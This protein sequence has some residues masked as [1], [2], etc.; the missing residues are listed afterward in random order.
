MK[1]IFKILAIASLG[2]VS[3]TSCTRDLTSLNVDPKHATTLPSENQLATAMYYTAYNMASPSVNSNN[4]RFF[5]Q[6]LAETTYIDETNYDL[7]TRLQPRN[8]FNNMYSRG[9]NPIRLAKTAL[10]AEANSTAI[11]NNKWATLELQEIFVWENL[12][13]TYGNIPYTDA[14]N[15]DQTLAPKYDDAA[16][17]YTDL[18]KRIDAAVAKISTGAAGY[19]NGGDLV[20]YGDMAKWKKFG[21]SLKL[22][23]AMNLADVNPSV[24]KSAAEAAVA[25][26]VMASNADSY[27]FKFDGGTFTNPVYDNFVASGRNDFI[28]TELVI[29][30]MNAKNDP[31]RAQWFT[32]VDGKYVG[33][34][35]GKGNS[36]AFFSHYTDMLT[37]ST[38]GANLLSYVEVLFL[39][40]EG[41]ARGY[42]MGGTAATFYAA[43]ITASMQEAGVAAADIATYL[44]THPYDAANWKKSIGEE[45]YIALFDRAFAAWNFTRRLDTPVFTNPADSRISGVPV[46]MPY[47]DQEYQLNQANVEAAATAIGGDK[48][49]T[50]L[51]W[52]KF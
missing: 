46:R 26:G 25:S 37:S 28:P 14:F 8:Y 7:V 20:Y 30:M 33:G 11:A 1:N 21:N 22:R 42:N 5:T 27:I 45:A 50:K 6:Q 38:A 40:A 49:T 44:A 47:S 17:I 13:D 3:L 12:V 51:F 9:I 19:T 39:K 24:S 10:E 35:F 16:T 43:A 15:P 23:M 29:N 18:L 34:V 31:R 48:A 32:T 52:D 4:Y 41:A 36:F 2:A